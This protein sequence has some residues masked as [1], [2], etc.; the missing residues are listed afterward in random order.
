MKMLFVFNIA[1][2]LP[3]TS[4]EPPKN[5]M[6]MFV[7]MLVIDRYTSIGNVSSTKS[8]PSIYWVFV[9]FLW[10]S[11]NVWK[12]HKHLKL[13]KVH[14]ENIQGVKLLEMQRT[15]P[16]RSHQK[17]VEVYSK[18]DL[19]CE[20]KWLDMWFIRCVS[21]GSFF[22]SSLPIRSSLWLLNIVQ[23]FWCWKF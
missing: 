9:N 7:N 3:E 4:K 1:F 15:I 6:F 20:Q 19:Y 16:L 22:I 11:P 5:D 13:A 18:N 10:A 8:L 12:I 23:L 17:C 2:N 14:L 21:L